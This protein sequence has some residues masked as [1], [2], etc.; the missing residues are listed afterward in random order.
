MPPTS[1]NFGFQGSFQE[2]LALYISSNAYKN[3]LEAISHPPHET[4]PIALEAE[5][6]SQDKI[7]DVPNLPDQ[8]ED[9]S[10]S[11]L[12]KTSL[13]KKLISVF[14]KKKPQNIASEE[15]INIKEVVNVEEVVDAEE[16]VDAKKVVEENF[17]LEKLI[18][19]VEKH[20]LAKYEEAIKN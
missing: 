14:K 18:D 5:S 12:K 9:M 2:S 6:S 15:P 17:D 20:N 19:I 7:K 8:I 16:A 13:F 3:V 11:P 10:H 1:R 4:I